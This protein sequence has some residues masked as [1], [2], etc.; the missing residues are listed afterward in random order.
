MEVGSGGGS[1][2]GMKVAMEVGV[3]VEVRDKV[4]HIDEE[5]GIL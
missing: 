4:R 1:G 5:F 3:W 2:S